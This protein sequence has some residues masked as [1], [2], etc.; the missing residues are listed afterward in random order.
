MM[1]RNLLATTLM[2][3]LL[4][5]R[6]IAAAP[7]EGSPDW[8]ITQDDKQA[9]QDTY[10]KSSDHCC[11]YA[12]GRPLNDN[13][14]RFNTT[15]QHYEVRYNKARWDSG[16]VSQAPATTEKDDVWLEVIPGKLTFDYQPWRFTEAWVSRWQDINGTKI[17][18]HQEI[19]C[20]SVRAGY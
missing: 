8:I 17:E 6:G 11:G 5:L 10:N 15:T 9:I 20:L 2:L 7:P 14:I 18:E 3:G 13:G 19:L 16:T 12:D 1:E 4:P